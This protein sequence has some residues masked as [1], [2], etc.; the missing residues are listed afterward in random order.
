MNPK[1]LFQDH[2]AKINMFPANSFKK[3]MKVRVIN[4]HS[5]SSKVKVLAKVKIFNK[6]MKVLIIYKILNL[7]LFQIK[8]SVNRIKASNQIASFKSVQKVKL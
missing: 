4:S 6:M 7:S 2:Q 3:I 8:I 1:N 5:L